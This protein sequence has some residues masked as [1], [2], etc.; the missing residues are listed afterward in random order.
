MSEEE[1]KQLVRDIVQMSVDCCGCPIYWDGQIIER[2]RTA[3]GDS[4]WEPKYRWK[5]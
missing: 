1:W 5:Q 4:S 2:I 3:L